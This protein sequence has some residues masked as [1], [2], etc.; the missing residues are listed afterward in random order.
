MVSVY[1]TWS[2]TVELSALS[3]YRRDAQHIS[4]RKTVDNST[5]S[6]RHR[7]NVSRT[8]KGYSVEATIDAMGYSKDEVI[9]QLKELMTDLEAIYPKEIPQA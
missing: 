7:A 1:T 8:S 5:T 4:R 9:A 2:V 3:T 6:L